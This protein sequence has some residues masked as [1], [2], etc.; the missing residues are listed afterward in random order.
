MRIPKRKITTFTGVSGSGKAS[1]VF[2]MGPERGTKG[3]K[4]MCED[5]PNQ[6]LAAKN[7][8]TGEYIRN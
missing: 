1:I 7:S 2:D 3:G 6:L 8:L 5:T 4:V